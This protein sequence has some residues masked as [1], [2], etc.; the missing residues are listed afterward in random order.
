MKAHLNSPDKIIVLRR[1]F[2]NR[3]IIVSTIII[4]T[5]LLSNC[6]RT[7]DILIPNKFV[8]KGKVLEPIVKNAIKVTVNGNPKI[9]VAW[10]LEEA[11]KAALEMSLKYSNMFGDDAN[12][13]YE[14]IVDIVSWDQPAGDF[15]MFTSTMKTH[16]VLR[17]EKKNIILEK[18][19]ITEAWS[20]HWYFVGNSRAKSATQMTVAKNV[21]QFMDILRKHYGLKSVKDDQDENKA[22]LSEELKNLSDLHTSGKLSDEEFKRAKE[23]LLNRK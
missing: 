18:T 15:G 19:F 21:N 13:A 2:R 4:F 17:D 12:S 23:I 22:S 7:V 10:K 16:Y 14:I 8:E 5:I 11:I 1:L 6:A 9:T 20:E 3:I